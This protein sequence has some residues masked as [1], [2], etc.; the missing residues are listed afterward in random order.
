VLGA[1]ELHVGRARPL[2]ARIALGGERHAVALLQ[3]VEVRPAGEPGAMEKDIL[4]PVLR[5]DEPE[6]AIGVLATV[7]IQLKGSHG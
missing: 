6:P 4:A 5:P 1:D 3:L 2:A 7:V